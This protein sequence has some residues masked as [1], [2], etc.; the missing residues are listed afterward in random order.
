MRSAFLLLVFL[1]LAR[2]TTPFANAADRSRPNIVWIVCEDSSPNLGCYGETQAITPTLDALAA[3]GVRYTNACAVSP[4]CSVSRSGII[5]G[6]YPT[7]V[8]THHHRSFIE[9]NATVNTPIRLAAHVR[10]FT[11]LLREAGYY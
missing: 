5:L 10:C 2:E 7:S 11:E 4:V 3:S 8:G 1:A 6:M 9:N